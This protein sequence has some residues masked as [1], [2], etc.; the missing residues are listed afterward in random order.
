MGLNEVVGTGADKIIEFSKKALDGNWKESR[1]PDLWDCESI[2]RGFARID[3]D[4]I[5]NEN[6]GFKISGKK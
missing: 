5:K 6:F 2:S 1:V 3:T 4:H